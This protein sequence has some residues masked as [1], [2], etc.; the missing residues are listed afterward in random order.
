VPFARSYFYTWPRTPR[1][2]HSLRRLAREV[3]ARWPDRATAS[4]GWIGDAAH[5]ATVSDHN[6]DSRGRVHALDVTSQ[7]VASGALVRAACAHPATHYVISQ[8]K[9]Y[10]RQH[11]FY[12]QKYVGADPH[13]SHVHISVERTR[14]GRLSNRSW[15]S[16][17]TVT[18]GG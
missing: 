18:L 10:E 15:L 6:P 3:D 13:E 9:I 7:G 14:A 2:V 16:S 17:S 8:G 11:G 4:D 1:L 5:A 12:P